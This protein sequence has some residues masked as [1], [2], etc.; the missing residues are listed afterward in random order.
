M[1]RREEHETLS[2]QMV[3]KDA[4]IAQL[5]KDLAVERSKTAQLQQFID[6]QRMGSKRVARGGGLSE[7]AEMD[8][9]E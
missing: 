3:E 2:K 1:R 7:D 4:R 6:L 5:E 8:D 9:D